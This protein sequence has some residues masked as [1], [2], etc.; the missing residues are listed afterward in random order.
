MLVDFP[1]AAAS[2][3][4]LS[5]MPC[6]P[7]RGVWYRQAQ[8]HFRCGT[9]SRVGSSSL[10]AAEQKDP[11]VNRV[12]RMSSG[13]SG[14][15]QEWPNS[16]QSSATLWALWICLCFGI[17]ARCTSS[18]SCPQECEQHWNQDQGDWYGAVCLL[19]RFQK[20]VPLCSV[21]WGINESILMSGSAPKRAQWSQRFT[22]PWAV[23]TCWPS[24]SLGRQGI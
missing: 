15:Q 8:P 10:A 4:A 3:K 12:Q 14:F 24:C 18:V 17:P 11:A 13:K 16:R 20:V 1:D 9:N 6:S 21:L 23:L 2:W 19:T 22:V 7:W 5:G